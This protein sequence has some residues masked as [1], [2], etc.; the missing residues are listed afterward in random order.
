MATS[1][2]KRNPRRNMGMHMHVDPNLP[3]DQYKREA[4]QRYLKK[5]LRCVKGVDDA[6][7]KVLDELDRQGIADNTLICYTGDQGFMLGE[8]D[9]IDKRWIYEEAMR[10]PFIV[11]YPAKVKAGGT[12]QD[13][14]GNIDFAPMILD[15][16]G[17]KVP[18][19]MQ[20]RSF[21][22]ML[23]GKKAPADWRDAI[24]YRYWLNM[25]SH[26]NPAHY[27]VRTK[28]Y[29]LI[30]FYGLPLD[31]PYAKPAVEPYWE[32]YDLSKDPHEMNNVYEDPA[33]HDIREQLKKKLLELKKQYK[34]TDE[35]YPEL[36]KVRAKYWE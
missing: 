14:I 1:I 29:K 34:D 16:A 23:L 33:Y 22:P 20:G 13:L 19:D 6:V 27:G 8:H 31:V 11:R 17:L 5:Y 18:G 32:M 3:D 30:F 21:Y 36:M 12:N 28:K 15:A 26:E 35:K 2:G 4:Y 10:M 9:Y 24:Y 7:G 25:V